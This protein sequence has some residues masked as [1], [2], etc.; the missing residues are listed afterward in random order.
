MAGAARVARQ[1]QQQGVAN[2]VVPVEVAVE[3]DDRQALLPLPPSR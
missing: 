2:R 1:R 3:D